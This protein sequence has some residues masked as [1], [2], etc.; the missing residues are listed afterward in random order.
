MKTKMHPIKDFP[1]TVNEL[2]NHP[3]W[4]GFISDK[5]GNDLFINDPDRADRNYNA[6]EDGA[7]G[8]THAEHIEDWREFVDILESE[9]SSLINCADSDE[10]ADKLQ[11]ELNDAVEFIRADIDKCE[12]WHVANGSIDEQIG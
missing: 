10:E 4:D 11:N 12:A 2:I 3:S 6:A 7:D 8:S 9:A 5:L 1:S